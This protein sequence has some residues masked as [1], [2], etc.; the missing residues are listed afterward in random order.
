MG[1]KTCSSK[2]YIEGLDCC[3]NY[4]L[5][6]KSCHPCHTGTFG[7]N[8]TGHCSPGTYGD[9]CGQKCVDCPKELCHYTYGCP[10]MATTT[11]LDGENDS[12]MFTHPGFTHSIEPVTCMDRPIPNKGM[13][14]KM[15]IINGSVI[16]AL[17]LVL[18]IITSIRKYLMFLYWKRNVKLDHAPL[19]MINPVYSEAEGVSG[20][21]IYIKQNK[22]NNEGDSRGKHPSC[23]E[24][25]GLM[26]FKV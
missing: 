1:E 21:D 7:I 2:T 17:L 3:V 11:I 4:F 22:R 26:C 8:C 19:T 14:S 12:T 5:R 13:I 18:I 10:K 25:L 9:S 6:N 23:R 24:E 20:D 15:I 16:I